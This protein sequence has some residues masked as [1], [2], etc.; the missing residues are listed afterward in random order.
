M[1]RSPAVLVLLA[2][3]A[4]HAI[5]SD[6]SSVHVLSA[7]D[8]GPHGIRP[9]VMGESG[10]D[11][12]APAADVPTLRKKVQDNSAKVDRWEDKNEALA[13]QLK[14]LKNATKG[15]IEAAKQ[16]AA[17]R[18]H[19]QQQVES[20][21]AQLKS[22]RARIHTKLKSM[23][24]TVNQEVQARDEK[25]KDYD[26][27]M[28]TA[29][30]TLEKTIKELD[31]EAA[32]KDEMMSENLQQIKASKQQTTKT[33]TEISRLQKLSAEGKAV[34]E[35]IKSKAKARLKQIS[36]IIEAERAKVAAQKQELV[37][38]NANYTNQLSE[39]AKLRAKAKKIHQKMLAVQSQVRG[40]NGTLTTL[41][42][43]H[44]DVQKRL[45]ALKEKEKALLAEKETEVADE[46]TAKAANAKRM[47]TIRVLRAEVESTRAKANSKAGQAK[48]LFTEAQDI[49]QKAEALKAKVD[50]GEEA[51]S[52]WE[53]VGAMYTEST[54]KLNTMRAQV[55]AKTHALEADIIRL[56]GKTDDLESSYSTSKK[57]LQSRLRDLKKANAQKQAQAET[58]ASKE[59]TLEMEIAK[60]QQL[61][62]AA[63]LKSEQ[64]D[65]QIARLKEKL[66]ALKHE[67][68]LQQDQSSAAVAKLR[69]RQQQL[70]AEMNEAKARIA[71]LKA[72]DES[73]QLE[74]QHATQEH[75]KVAGSIAAAHEKKMQAG[76]TKI[77]EAKANRVHAEKEAENI[78]KVA[79]AK[80]RKVIA[81]GRHAQRI[82]EQKEAQ[83]SE[84]LAA[85]KKAIADAVAKEAKRI[86]N[87]KSEVENT[88]G[89]LKSLTAEEQA[90]QGK[91]ED[92]T[93]QKETLRAELTRI[94][95][96]AA[97]SLKWKEMEAHEIVKQKEAKLQLGKLESE[98][99][100]HVIKLLKDKLS[101]EQ[102][103]EA[104]AEKRLL[105]SDKR[106]SQLEDSMED[107]S[108]QLQREK[109]ELN[110]AT[111]SAKDLAAQER[112]SEA[113]IQNHHL[114]LYKEEEAISK[115]AAAEQNE[116]EVLEL[117][118]M[119]ASTLAAHLGDLQAKLDKLEAMANTKEGKIAEDKAQE[120]ELKAQLSKEGALADSDDQK[121]AQEEAALAAARSSEASAGAQLAGETSAHASA[122][123]M[124]KAI[125]AKLA[126]AEK[127]LNS[128][129]SQIDQERSMIDAD[130]NLY[131]SSFDKDSQVS[132]DMQRMQSK[133]QEAADK[134]SEEQANSEQAQKASGT[135]R[136]RIAAAKAKLSQLQTDAM[137]QEQS[138]ASDGA[139]KRG[140]KQQL[141]D[142][143]ARIAKLKG[144][145]SLEKQKITD[146]QSA[147]SDEEAKL[148]E[149]EKHD[150]ASKEELSAMIQEKTAQLRNATVELNALQASVPEITADVTDLKTKNKHLQGEIE[151]VKNKEEATKEETAALSAEESS[152]QSML[153]RRQQSESGEAQKV[154]SD[155]ASL[156]A[157]LAEEDNLKAQLLQMQLGMQ[158]ETAALNSAKSD[159]AETDKEVSGLDHTNSELQKGISDAQTNIDGK[160]A[161]L[162]NIESEENG[163]LNSEELQEFK[164][165]MHDLEQKDATEK[166]QT[167]VASAEAMHAQ[168]DAATLRGRLHALD[169]RFD[170]VKAEITSSKDEILDAQHSQKREQQKEQVVRKVQ[171]SWDRSLADNKESHRDVQAQ[172]ESARDSIAAAEEKTQA[173]LKAEEA[174]LATATEQTNKW[175]ASLSEAAETMK[176]AEGHQS[177]IKGEE[178][179]KMG[180]VRLLDAEILHYNQ[181]LAALQ[182]RK[183]VLVQSKLDDLETQT[184]PFHV[185][186]VQAM[187][188]MARANE[189]R[190]DAMKKTEAL[191]NATAAPEEEEPL[192]AQFSDGTES[193]TP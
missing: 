137:Q 100:E 27:H 76:R 31:S 95:N 90:L 60:H 65:D 1:L 149:L 153:A 133:A 43:S 47:S 177:S 103:S 45:H 176:V 189:L 52:K 81:L 88:K 102:Q 12:A 20:L 191:V 136:E 127:S 185:E 19:A 78:I 97:E 164:N 59:K 99:H 70:Q 187:D 34:G 154:Q 171:E 39:P 86:R 38:L 192:D 93:K 126:N 25:L 108:P 155:E 82:L 66:A 190:S 151:Q 124:L 50:Q 184:A 67:E 91:I 107:L 118:Q 84:K 92:L 139:V 113:Q 144:S 150:S 2:I 58:A 188:K 141:N 193:A 4:V 24:D 101:N 174:Q 8:V 175:E 21:Q 117:K 29:E 152:T 158:G 178:Q 169:A 63:R 83:L 98:K 6:E 122:E 3:L 179:Q 18:A 68:Q 166:Q 49:I 61:S 167:S 181:R 69:H 182:E 140:I 135:L 172:R 40:V 146:E 28:A 56:S 119:K 105:S 114:A 134:L 74:L 53:R 143:F 75:T 142:A 5:G 186:A 51:T 94:Q 89:T 15:W 106:K 11:G 48:A 41:L 111:Q 79:A 22:E 36:L 116:A 145:I 55:S 129:N 77:A 17:G 62:S 148:R 10:V 132:A 123:D 23:Q 104:D 26:K 159:L 128:Q 72:H 44:D 96:R 14:A 54:D 138:V 163:A 16:S 147:V 110:A 170:H 173:Q 156:K 183:R 42:A 71:A 131:Q 109:D 112:D 13:S 162:S 64:I 125:E 87:R 32:A 37:Y 168:E 130:G 161:Q 80:Q 180:K 46:E 57:R 115:A 73:A 33:Q 157:A 9:A 120:G 30:E 35:D 121:L 160:K 165:K 85:K 7:E